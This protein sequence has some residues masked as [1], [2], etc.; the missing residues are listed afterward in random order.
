M[1]CIDS[2]L[3]QAIADR[4][5]RLTYKEEGS[6]ILLNTYQDV[7]PHLEYAAKVRRA[8]REHGSSKRGEFRHT[9]SLPYN[10]ILEIAQRLGIA[11]GRIFGKEE[12]QRIQREYK[13]SDY[14]NFR[15]TDG[16]R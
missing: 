2:S 4:A 3:Q 8:D 10:V 13:S 9:H 7:E 16:R 11:F 1:I 5:H 15:T 14:K 6:N 12:W